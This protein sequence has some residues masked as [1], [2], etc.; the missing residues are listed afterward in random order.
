MPYLD[1]C[2]AAGG[3]FNPFNDAHGMP[4]ATERHV[5]DL[6]NIETPGS[7][8]ATPV[9]KEDEIISLFDGDEGIVG[10][11]LVI[12]AG[13]DDFMGASGNAGSRVACGI[14]ELVEATEALDMLPDNLKAKL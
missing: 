12:H 9:D 11:T 2:V 8:M 1:G 6:G 5:G 13:E 14:V 10:R 7:G 3:H 4:N